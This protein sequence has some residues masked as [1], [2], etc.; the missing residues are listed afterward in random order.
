[1]ASDGVIDYKAWYIVMDWRQLVMTIV[2]NF[3]D[4]VYRD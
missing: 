2:G 4:F 1:V 3:L